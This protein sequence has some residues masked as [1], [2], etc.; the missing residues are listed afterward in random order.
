MEGTNYQSLWRF[1]RSGREPECFQ[2]TDEPLHDKQSRVVQ[3]FPTSLQEGALSWFT[4]LPPNFVDSF[5]PLA[6]KFTT[7]YVMSW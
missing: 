6:A 4:R 7:Q 3:G 1:H 2:D 5:K